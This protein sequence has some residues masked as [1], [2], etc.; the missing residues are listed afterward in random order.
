M[1]QENKTPEDSINEYVEAFLD[2]Y[3]TFFETFGRQMNFDEAR[4]L[5]KDS[6]LS[7]GNYQFN[8]A[9]ELAAQSAKATMVRQPFVGILPEVDKE[10]ILALKI[11]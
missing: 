6:L 11:K 5:V 9:I 10:S 8:R 1:P 2:Q 7:F 4:K 3:D